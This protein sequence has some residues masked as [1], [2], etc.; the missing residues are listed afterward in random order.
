MPAFL[1]VL[2]LVVV[3][4]FHHIFEDEDEDENDSRFYC[5]RRKKTVGFVGSMVT[6]TGL[7]APP[8]K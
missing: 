6:F 8:G 2:V 5:A 3:L 1:L 4:D 7:L